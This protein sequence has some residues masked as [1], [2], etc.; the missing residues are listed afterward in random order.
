MKLKYR[1]GSALN[2]L[3][4]RMRNGGTGDPVPE[5]GKKGYSDYAAD[6]AFKAWLDRTGNT[7][8]QEYSGEALHTGGGSGSVRKV[9]GDT[10]Y[11]E[12]AVNPDLLPMESGYG[13]EEY[14]RLSSPGAS[15]GTRGGQMQQAAEMFENNRQ[16]EMAYEAWLAKQRKMPGRGQVTERAESRPGQ[17]DVYVR[18]GPGS[19]I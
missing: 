9:L 10:P 11:A 15:R 19:A 14:G 8:S 12:M 4:T 2:G 3:V 17:S 18:R 5:E 16:M 1:A 13:R 6:P 7:Y